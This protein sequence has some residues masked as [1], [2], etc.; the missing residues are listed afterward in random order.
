MSDLPVETPDKRL[1]FVY[2]ADGGPLNALRDI[3]VRV[4][5][6]ADY[7][8][9]L[10]RLT[11]GVRGMDG[12]WRQFTRSLG[13]PVAF[14]HRDEFREQFATSPLRDVELPAAVVEDRGALV[15]VVSAG[16]MRAAADLD[17]LMDAVTGGL[18]R[19]DKLG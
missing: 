3:W 6:P 13:L 4:A 16:Q 1:V 10:C 2:N 14:L 18:L 17:R 9:A 11:Y 8:C 12:R 19:A 5:R 15:Q 7:A